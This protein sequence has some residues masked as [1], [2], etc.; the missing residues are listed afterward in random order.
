MPNALQYAA[1]VVPRRS[2][3]H[4]CAGLVIILHCYNT[5]QVHRCQHVCFVFVR[6][7]RSLRCVLMRLRHNRRSGGS[8]DLAFMRDNVFDRKLQI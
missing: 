2:A 8:R 4:V 3:A 7:L 6:T 5:M 1:L